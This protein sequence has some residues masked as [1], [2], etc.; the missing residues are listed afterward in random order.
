MDVVP[1]K[2]R[3]VLT[4]VTITRKMGVSAESAWSALRTFGRLDVWFP[5]METCTIEGQGV[6]AHRHM[7]LVGGLGT[8]TDRFVAL[9]D[10]ARRLQY[11]RP[12]SP[13]PVTSYTGTVEVFRSFDSLA[14]VVWTIDFD[15]SPEDSG[16][17]GDILKGAI[18]DGLEGME[19][20]LRVAPK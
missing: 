8:I 16:P 5:S 20:D 13:F 4:K 12:E 18:A 17:V 6:G 7:S 19:A 1:G 11:E 10:D 2:G 3:S 9:D 14:I 15:S